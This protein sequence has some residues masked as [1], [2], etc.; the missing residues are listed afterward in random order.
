MHPINAASHLTLAMSSAGLHP[1]AHTLPHVLLPSSTAARLP[2][3]AAPCTAASRTLTGSPAGLPHTQTIA[4]CT[5]ASNH[6]LPASATHHLPFNSPSSWDRDISLVRLC[7]GPPAVGPPA[8]GFARLR[9]VW[10]AR[11]S[12]PP[13]VTHQ[14]KQSMC[15]HTCS[16]STVA[17]PMCT[18][19]LM[20][21]P[22]L[23]MSLLMACFTRL[24]AT[25]NDSLT[26]YVTA[27]R[28]WP[29]TAAAA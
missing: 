5:A 19:L 26:T 17:L 12:P 20:W 11:G 8:V 14:Q 6:M 9:C 29:A 23:G 15:L 3:R 13:L 21:S 24:V 25:T 16:L 18:S 28:C 10:P 1:Y 2:Y 27:G 22:M 7:L 4:A